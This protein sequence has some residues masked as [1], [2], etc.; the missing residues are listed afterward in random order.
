MH[1][2]SV[3]T[4]KLEGSKKFREFVIDKIYDYIF[5]GELDELMDDVIT[6]KPGK[7]NK[8]NF[9]VTNLLEGGDHA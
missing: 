1:K 4:I 9:S 6:V 5:D 8:L 3:I 7:E 2:V